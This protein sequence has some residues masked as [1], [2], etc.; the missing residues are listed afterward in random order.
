MM[1]ERIRQYTQCWLAACRYTEG[2][3]MNHQE[4]KDIQVENYS[5]EADTVSVEIDYE[6]VLAG[7]I[8][9]GPRAGETLKLKGTTIFTYKDGVIVYL[10]DYS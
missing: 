3:K 6:G 2:R 5:F 10:V 8:P 1:G 4:M 9:N 7:D